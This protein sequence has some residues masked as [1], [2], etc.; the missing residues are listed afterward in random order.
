MKKYSVAILQHYYGKL[1]NYFPLWLKTAGANKNFTFMMFTDCDFSGYN[2]PDNFHPVYMKFDELRARIAKY[3]DFD[4]VCDTPY[5]ACDYI[6]LHGLMFQDYLKG[7]DFWGTCDPDEIWGDMNKFITDD[8]LDRYD[9]IYR[10]GHLQLFRNTPEVNNFA[11]HE[12]PG[13]NLSY[14]HIFKTRVHI[15]YE[16]TIF[17]ENLFNRYVGE[18]KQYDSLDFADINPIYKQFICVKY[19]RNAESVPAFRWDNG[20]LYGL[21]V[22]GEKGNDKEYIYLHLQKR[23]MKFVP[24]IEHEDSFLIVPN[25]FVKDHELS[26]EE[27]T[28]YITP[29]PVYEH[30]RKRGAAYFFRKLLD[31]DMMGRYIKLMPYFYAMIGKRLPSQWTEAVNHRRIYN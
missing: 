15:A 14:K 27:I 30:E 28:R 11:L 23:A 5:K 3:L 22:N 9:R 20:K 2:L 6:L 21:A 17:S 31:F 29:D 19:M 16:E 12:L 7:Y 25:E 18:G 4:F 26:Q 8:I 24:D 13:W 1:P 10:L